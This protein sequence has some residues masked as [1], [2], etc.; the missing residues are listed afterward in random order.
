MV[1]IRDVPED[2]HREP[3]ERAKRHDMSLSDHLLQEVTVLSEQLS[4]EELL[5]EIDRD[6]PVLTEDVDT[7]ELIRQEREERERQLDARHLRDIP[8]E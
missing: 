5:E 1:Q 2:V 6:G 3:R 8:P 7:V 4:W